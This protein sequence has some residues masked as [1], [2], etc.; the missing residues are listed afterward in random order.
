MTAP[1]VQKLITPPIVPQNIV[2][3]DR[4]LELLL[5][6]MEKNLIL[7]YSPAGYGKT[8]LIQSFLSKQNLNFGWLNVTSEI[9]HV[10]TFFKYLVYSLKRIN[11]NFGTDTL[12]IIDSWNQRFQ[13]TRNPKNAINDII[14]TFIKEFGEKFKEDIILVIDDLQY[15]EESKWFRETFNTLFD[16]IPSNLHLV[17]ITRQ[18]P[19]FNVLPLMEKGNLLK[20]GMEDLIFRFDEIITLLKEIYAIDYSEDGIKLLENNLGGWITGIHL[21]LQSYGKD[22]T[23]LKLDYQKIPENIFN[24]LADEIFNRLD[25]DTQNFL[26]M[27]SLLDGFNADLCNHWL[28]I[29]NSDEI[30]KTLIEKNL[31]IHPVPLKY[32]S[33]NGYKMTYNYQTL[34]KRF[35][36]QKLNESHSHDFIKDNLQIVFKYYHDKG[37]MISAI[38]YL[39]KAKDFK[40]VIP[41]IIENFDRL[42]AE[43]KFEFLWKWLKTIED[44]IEVHNPY[45][46]YYLGMLYKYFVGDLDKSLEYL[47]KAIL[48]FE[49]HNDQNTLVGCH[50]TKSGV[51]MNL[52]KSEE[53]IPE[54]KRL[55]NKHTTNDIRTNLLY[56]LA[57]A[58]YQ[59]AEYDSSS[60]LLKEALRLGDNGHTIKKKTDVYNLLGNIELIK[61]NFRN[62]VPYYEKAL[63]NNPD[64]FNR[65]ETL[66]N[67][68]LMNSQSGDYGKA[69]GFM[70]NLDELIK[71]FPTPLFKLPHLMT[72]QAYLFE[73]GKFEENIKVLEQIIS[74]AKYM[75]HKQYLYLSYRLLIDTY[76]YRNELGKAKEYLSISEQFV[77]KNNE[78][79]NIEL[80]TL[81]ALL[82]VERKD[83]RETES[84]LLSSYKYYN[85]NEYIYPKVQVAY[86]LANWY[87]INNNIE[88]AK[89]FVDESLLIAAE[90]N[91]LSFFVREYR[92]NNRLINFCMENKLHTE[93]VNSV[94]SASEREQ[95]TI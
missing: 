29:K 10:Y 26:M 4:L 60:A 86:R 37:D 53:V 90:N 70:N 21:I 72:K 79:E 8:T 85:D 61:G 35:L 9:D 12:E 17:I 50:V 68:V 34:F 11:E 56:F 75:N 28:E 63:Q 3:R 83:D 91:Y 44:E 55:L 32:D 82:C 64:L 74:I 62:S 46:I 36:N 88:K 45:I 77:E 6:N 38:D 2:S 25:A 49:K 51:L 93:F 47:E 41:V 80:K 65:I 14:S 54:L 13:A 27:T 66:C 57:Y 40:M 48:L 81:K 43:G 7:V 76:Y 42:F 71:K 22:F 67:L 84:G 31:F 20:I 59:N 89:E 1:F 94:V 92:F 33:S 69:N 95:I 5:N 87:L 19:N 58:Y 24:F 16:I 39:I 30:I 52:G 18:I 15:I 78:L 73:S 23:S